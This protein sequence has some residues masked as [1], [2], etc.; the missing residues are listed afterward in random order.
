[1]V[2]PGGRASVDLAER[3]QRET[4]RFDFFQ[5]VRLLERLAREGGLPGPRAGHQPVGVDHAPEQECVRFRTVPSLSFLTAAAARVRRPSAPDGSTKDDVPT[6]EMAVAF[7]G[8][9]GSAGVLPAHYTALLMRRVRAKDTSLRDLL[10]LFNHRLV[11]L[12]YRAW[13]KYRLPFAYERARAGRGPETA[14]QQQV[15]E[16]PERVTHALYS[17]VGRGTAGLRGR[18]EIPDEAFLY[19][20]GHFAHRPRSAAA[21]E[22]VLADYFA[23][24]VRVLQFQGQ[25]L[26]LEREDQAQLPS[27]RH[28]RGLN[29][30]LGLDLVVGERVWA[31]Q[32]K[33]RLRVGPLTY[34]QFRGLMPGAGKRLRALSQMARSYVGPEFVFDVQ[35]VLL[36]AEVPRLWLGTDGDD[37]PYLGWN[38]WVHS[39]PVAGDVE[40]AVFPEERG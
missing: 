15:G 21:L 26:R 40:D 8:L 28:P 29:N 19:Y 30:R 23:F 6:L 37:R 32:S 25:S 35:L 27:P 34:R 13:E 33:F 38:T 17:L 2:P 12:F 9:T 7:L 14:P 16:D 24:P 18:L 4:Y 36:G 1:M 20:G 5:A 3:L 31:V 11:S 22:L 39:G 10:D